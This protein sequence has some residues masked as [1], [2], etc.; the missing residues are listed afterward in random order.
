MHNR[1]LL[2]SYNDNEI[3]Y[4]SETII[5]EEFKATRHSHSNFEILFFVEGEGVVVSDDSKIKVSKNNILIINSK[6]MHY[7]MSDSSCRFFALGINDLKAFFKESFNEDIINLS[8]NDYDS[9]IIRNLYFLIYNE[10]MYKSLNYVEIVSNYFNNILFILKRNNISFIKRND[11]DI[12]QVVYSIKNILDNY[13][14]LPI[15][16]ENIALKLSMSQSSICHQF[17]K[18]MNM[19]IIEYKINK[20]IEEAKNL[21]LITD[22]NMIEICNAVGLKDSSYFSKIFKKKV[23]LTPK[24]YRFK[25]KVNNK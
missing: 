12:S 4:I 1:M 6:T 18:E 21:L 16:I 22:M 7:E 8:L 3:L 23:N 5:D 9:K 13:F 15:K 10:V 17:K 11:K 20:Q 25:N 24:E 14:Y 19:S 2:P